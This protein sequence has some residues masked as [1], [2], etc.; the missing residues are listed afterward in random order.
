MPFLPKGYASTCISI[1]FDCLAMMHGWQVGGD[2][3]IS[4]DAVFGLPRR[5][6]AGRMFK[7]SLHGHLWF[8]DQT[9]V[10]TYVKF[11]QSRKSEKQ[12][13]FEGLMMSTMFL[14]NLN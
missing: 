12:C 11:S 7:E 8:A 4:M 9:D 3:I 2:V 14:L 6:N 13:G 5:K 10:D 1:V